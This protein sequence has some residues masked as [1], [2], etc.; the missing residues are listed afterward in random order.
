MFFVSLAL[1]SELLAVFLAMLEQWYD[2]RN[3]WGKQK[4]DQDPASTFFFVISLITGF[5]G[6]SVWIAKWWLPDIP[7]VAELVEKFASLVPLQVLR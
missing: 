5:C 1:Y 7:L 6:P 3:F 4:S 2:Y